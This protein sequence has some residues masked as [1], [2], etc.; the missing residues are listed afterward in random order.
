MIKKYNTDET[1]EI[2]LNTN[3]SICRLG[4]GELKII[5]DPKYNIGFQRNSEELRNKLMTILHDRPSDD[6]LV[7][8]VYLENPNEMITEDKRNYLLKIINENNRDYK[9]GS[10]N[11]TRSLKYIESFKKIWNNRD[12]TL[13]EGEYTRSGIGNDLFDNTN[14]ISRVICPGIN[15]FDK[16]DEIFSYIKNNITKDSLLL[17]S[18]G[19]TATVLS[20]ELSKIGY[21]VLDIGHLD[22]IYEWRKIGPGKYIIKGKYVNEVI[23]GNIID[24]IGDCE[25]VNYISQIV[26]KIK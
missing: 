9:F 2:L 19:P 11:I 15:A 7:S 21:R 17:C 23:N 1:M 24:E 12:I 10:A 6:I 20:Y 13:I 5:H 16:Y 3:K 8:V 14:S 18:L 25:D 22:I 26:K 4:D